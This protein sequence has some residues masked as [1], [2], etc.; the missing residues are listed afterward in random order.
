MKFELHCHSLHSHGGKIRWEGLA[1]PSHIVHML[2]KRGIN[3]FAITDHDSIAGWKEAKTAA[4]R[5]GMVFIHSIEIS[6]LCGH[7]IALGVNEAVRPGLSVEETIDLIHDQGGLAIAPHPFDIRK[8]GIGRD[9]S[10]CDAVEVFNSLNLTK[11]ENLLADMQAKKHGVPAVGGSD[12]HSLKMLGMT[13]NH[14]NADD[15]DSALKR[16][17]NG[18]VKIQGRYIPIHIV[19]DWIR[20]RMQLS[21]DDINKYIGK[22]YSKPKSLL[23]KSMLDMFVSSDSGAWNALGYFAV[24][25]SMIYSF[26]T[27]PLRLNSF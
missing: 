8:E 17:R 12:A 13:V 16:I 25:A 27:L 2:K 24:S 1:S 10:R 3:G 15:A 21:Y 11:I 19:I 6:T 23:A 4:K 18:D 9:F 14:I 26:L 22:N 5:E 7:L 20:N